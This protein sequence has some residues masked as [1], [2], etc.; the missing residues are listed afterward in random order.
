MVLYLAGAWELLLDKK[1][2]RLGVGLEVP[3]F[4]HGDRGRLLGTA[5]GRRR[6]SGSAQ[7]ALWMF[8]LV[9]PVSLL[10][11]AWRLTCSVL[12]TSSDFAAAT[13]T[14]WRSRRKREALLMSELLFD[15]RAFC[16][17]NR[18]AICLP[19]VRRHAA[20]QPWPGHDSR[21]LGGLI[22]GIFIGLALLGE[23]LF[24]TL[25]LLAVLCYA[26]LGAGYGLG[27]NAEEQQF[28]AAFQIADQMVALTTSP[29]L[30]AI[31][32]FTLAGAI[33]TA[34]GIAQRLV[35]VM[36][37]SVGWLP[38]GLGIA[39]IVACA[40]FAAL[41]GSSAVTIIAIGAM[42]APT[43][44]KNYGRP[45]SLGLL[46]SCGAIGILAPPS[47]PL[48]V[49]GVISGADVNKLF[50]AGVIPGLLTVGVLA[51]Y[52]V[53]RGIEIPRH[54]STWVSSQRRF[55]GT[56]ALALPPLRWLASTGAS[57]RRP[58]IRPCG[59]IRRGGGGLHPPR[60]QAEGPLRAD[61]RHHD[62]GGVDPHHPADGT[63]AQQLP[64]A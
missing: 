29:V 32:M 58:G 38:G 52:C 10:L 23:A 43:L 11:I 27:T 40:F 16:R 50:I 4:V 49:Y 28:G 22:P 61:G 53:V 12:R 35:R 44:E 26:Y 48:I 5:S 46:T 9:A 18:L 3:G 42:L 47:L 54:P 62:V 51:L 55:A 56:L 60:G 21:L 63:G 19:A 7:D 34:G 15:A 2:Q 6:A 30:L 36:R 39:T 20:S 45:F 59:G 37:A 17:G 41:S 64:D 13:S 8:L 25:G 14:I 1:M 33:M 24:V 31:P 57:D